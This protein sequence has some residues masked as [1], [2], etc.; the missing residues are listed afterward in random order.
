MALRWRGNSWDG[1]YLS[2]LRDDFAKYEREIFNGKRTCPFTAEF[3][4]KNGNLIWEGPI[5]LTPGGKP[6]IDIFKE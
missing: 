1:Y 2:G 3:R 5:P 6:K 4:D